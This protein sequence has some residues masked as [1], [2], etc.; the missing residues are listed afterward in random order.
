MGHGADSHHISL[1]RFAG[2]FYFS[3]VVLSP[4]F[5]PFPSLPPPPFLSSPLLLNYPLV[6]HYIFYK[7]FLGKRLDIQG[8]NQK[9]DLLSLACFA[10]IAAPSTSWWQF[11][12]H[13]QVGDPSKIPV[14]C[15]LLASGLNSEVSYN[16]REVM[17]FESW[18]MVP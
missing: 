13:Q 17:H 4:P 11:L 7:V 2:L 1:V 3:H 14:P 8:S 6:S 5:P 15:S 9:L 18:T 10:L 12:H 16:R